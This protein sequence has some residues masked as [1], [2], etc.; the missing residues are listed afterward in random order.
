MRYLQIFC[1]FTFAIGTLLGQATTA[2][3]GGLVSDTQGAAIAG[4]RVV[5]TNT[6]TGVP[7]PTTTNS[8]G[9]YLLSNLEIGAYTLS[10]EHEGF[11]RYTQSGI[12]LSTA[13]NLALNVQLEVGQ[14]SESVNVTAEAATLEERTSVV[15]QTIQ[16][17]DVEDLPL[18]N[19]RTMNVINL[20]PA[21]VFV[22]YD[23][24]QKP[25]FSLAGGRTQSQMFWIDGGSGQNMRLGIG[26]ID[27]DPPAESV[28]EIQVLSN[29]YSAEYGAS[30]GG[31]IIETT[32]SGTNKLHGSLYEYLR[33]NVFDAPGYFATV[34]NGKKITPELR[35]NIFGGT[36]GGP[37]RRNKTFFFFST[38]AQRLRVGTVTTL[39]VPSLL[40]RQGDF[41]Q[42][43]NAAGALIPVYDPQTTDTVAGKTVRTAF[44]GNVIPANRLDPVALKILAYYPLPN[45]TPDNISGSSNFRSNGVSG[46]NGNYYMGKVDH[47]FSEKDRLLAR[48]I[49][50][51]G[52]ND[53]VSA[54][55]LKAAD[56]AAYILAHQQY[57]YANLIHIFSPAVV[58]DLRFNYGNRTALSL[59]AGVGSGVIKSL[60]LTGV[61]ENAFPQI[62]ASGFANLGSNGQERRQFPIQNLQYLDNVSWIHGKHAMKFGFEARLSSNYEVNLS[63]ASGAFTFGT[64]PTG[65]PGSAATGNG[66]ASLLL[67]FPTAFSQSST[68]VLDRSSWYLAGFAQDDF[69]IRP[70]LTFNIGLRWET[71][72]PI[73]DANNRMNGFDAHQLNPVSGT[74]GVVKFAGLNGWPKQPYSTDLNNFGPR[75]GFAWKPF[76]AGRTVVRGGYG[77][78]YAH[79]FDSGQPASA[80][81]GFGMNQAFNTPDNGIT[82][83]FYLRQGVPAG[84][85]SPA[86]TDSFGAV[87]VGK[88]TTT[89][90]TFFDPTRRTGY[91]QQFNLGVQHQL[92]GSL[93]L[94]VSGL[95]NISH[96]L[97]NTNITINQIQPGLLGPA[98]QS[99]A[100]RPYPQ[101]TNVTILSP[102][103]GDGR[104]LGGFIRMQ[105]RF[106]QGLTLNASYT[107]SQ[108]LDN[109][110]EGGST[111]GSD[112]GIYSNQY[113]RRADWGPSA[114]DVRHR[115]VF[116]SVYDLPFGYGKR[117]LPD[118]L[119]GQV[120]GGWTLAA[121]TALQSAAPFTVVT[122]T[123]STNAFSAGAQ[124]ANVVG[125]P[126]RLATKR[127]VAQWFNT[128]AFAQPAPF[129]FGNEGRDALRGSGLINVDISVLR[130]FKIREVL[131]LQFRGEFLNAL[132]HTNLGLPNAT[133][134]SAGF[135]TITAAG[136]ARQIQLGAKIQF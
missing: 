110:F 106:S 119:F 134:G 11:R 104:Y 9:T 63:T 81:L 108:F 25:N 76:G 97:P 129:T 43:F 68:A 12:V 51:S 45:R 41:S 64:Q 96:K 8:S 116:S 3:I 79:P 2:V 99:Q 87:P 6:A 14:V 38:E 60:G 78:S 33:N 55:P 107:Y 84:P 118:G 19:R 75:F 56:P 21:V 57:I 16:S 111:A 121:V 122:Q 69:T 86:L 20:S 59:T 36:V 90:V 37:I 4:A 40:Q 18:G 67:G 117:W 120:I 128:G 105:Q 70:N 22:G 62:V 127:S 24:G 88:A 95:G 112:G 113:N 46:L 109:S 80:G 54:Y 17:R 5:A 1:A 101:F 100:D 28:Q 132:N 48:Y 130:N 58:N 136:P 85:P 93:V 102:L 47:N 115:F 53:V 89:A 82:A 39:T 133:F 10:V 71:D 124:R 26:Q 73:T 135:G 61:S 72:T 42:T 126:N 114:N 15:G 29:N 91:S 32:K 23:A 83:P 74:P 35:Y 52:N 94:E 27:I 77:I 7:A 49:Y 34:Q 65:L 13:E 125:D 31:V 92:A 123:N 98:H 66:L 44:P 30:A 50:N 131:N 103:I